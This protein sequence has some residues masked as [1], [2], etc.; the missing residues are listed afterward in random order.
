MRAELV[1][2]QDAL[3]HAFPSCTASEAFSPEGAC[4]CHLVKHSGAELEALQAALQP[5]FPACTG[6]NAD[7]ARGI[8][9]FVPHFSL[10]QWRSAADAEAAA[11]VSALLPC[12]AICV[13]YPHCCEFVPRSSLQ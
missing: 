12:R 5:A 2:L 3:Q 1:T 6:L 8:T 13:R 9:E 11:K 10:G 7:P 4:G